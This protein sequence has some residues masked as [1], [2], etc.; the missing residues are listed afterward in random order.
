MAKQSQN[1][2]SRSSD[3]AADE[4]GLKRRGDNVGQSG[5]WTKGDPSVD[6]YGNEEGRH[7][8]EHATE[9]APGTPDEA[10]HRTPNADKPNASRY[11]GRFASPGEAGEEHG[12][13]KADHPAGSYAEAGGTAGADR[14]T[15]PG[16]G[17]W[18]D[19]GGAGYGEQYGS[20]REAG[21]TG[22]KPPAPRRRPG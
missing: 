13:D 1:D 12:D 19:E 18:Q 6:R 14:P 3:K 7:S 15:H 2:P 4:E 5:R 17:R 8:T 22:A 20:G 11:E 9:H 10:P 16:D 21:D